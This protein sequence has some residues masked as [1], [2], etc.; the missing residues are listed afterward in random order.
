MF[1]KKKTF[2]ENLAF[3]SGIA[4]G[5]GGVY[6]GMPPELIFIPDA[7]GDDVPVVRTRFCSMVG[8]FMTGTK[9]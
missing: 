7:D 1:D 2:T 5:M 9:P 4:V 6:V 3:S 8:A